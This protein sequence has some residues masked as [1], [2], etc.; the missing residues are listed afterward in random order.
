MRARLDGLTGVT[1]FDQRAF[2]ATAYG[3]H[4]ARTMELVLFGLIAVCVVIVLRYRRM[5]PILAALMAL[6]PDVRRALLRLTTCLGHQ[7]GYLEALQDQWPTEVELSPS[8]ARDDPRQ[9]A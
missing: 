2:L 7:R 3:E 1:V 5:R 6:G 9:R 8:A 4:R